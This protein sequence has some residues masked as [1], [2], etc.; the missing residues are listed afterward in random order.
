VV[1]GVGVEPDTRLA[2]AAGLHVDN[3]IVV[4]ELLRTSAEDV[5]AAGD[6][7]NAFH[8][9][10]GRHVRVEHWGNALHQGPAAA[11]SMLDRGEPY[12]RLPYFFSDQFSL[13]MEYV[14]L[15]SSADRVAVRRPSEEL[16]LQA[17]WVDADDRI[18]AGMHIN[19]WDTIEAIERMIGT[20]AGQS[21]G[22]SS[23]SVS[24]T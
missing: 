7:A 18:T 22:S 15:H 14:G 8:P 21:S 16:R 4:D 24:S 5:F 20:A 23:S 12:T 19:D 6:V 13:G 17:F 1:V 3:G 9:R 2:V 11:R 10:F